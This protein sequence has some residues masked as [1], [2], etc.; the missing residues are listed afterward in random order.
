ME[1]EGN[2]PS[3]ER[4]DEARE[5]YERL[6]LPLLVPVG[7]FL[8]SVLVIYGL[9]RI[10]L[11]LNTANI[12][13][14]G[15]ATPLA[16]GVS[17]AILGV[18][19]YLASRPSVA[20]WQMASVAAVSVALLT[21]GAIW[22]AVHDEGEAEDGGVVEPT[23]TA[24]PGAIQVELLDFAVEVEPAS[25]TADTIT[26]IVTNGGAQV[27]NLRLIETEL[28]PDALPLDDDGIVVDEEQVDV[29]GS[30]A[31]LSGG[32]DEELSV[33]LEAG[34]YVLICNVPT[35]YALGMS[36]AFTVE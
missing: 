36:V 22:A 21:G 30:V 4:P 34:S 7:V 14:V 6:A 13:D 20:R 26:F 1:P 25:A 19:W 31:E 33:E 11:E 2:E 8:F 29:V 16:I 10:Y 12:G 15:M 28:A 35:H 9:S 17:L 18:A 32:E 27:H 24:V 3:R 23:G 5:T